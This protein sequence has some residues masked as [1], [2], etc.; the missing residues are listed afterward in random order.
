MSSL[1][2][3]K[4]NDGAAAKIAELVQ[5]LELE[6]V[7]VSAHG[8]IFVLVIDESPIRVDGSGV[9]ECDGAFRTGPTHTESGL[10]RIA[11]LGNE[12]GDAVQRTIA[13]FTQASGGRMLRGPR[14][15]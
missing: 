14:D 8:A 5:G 12:V 13:R 10:E 7:G 1:L 4:Y 11:M 15:K 6:A 3:K 2:H 9:I